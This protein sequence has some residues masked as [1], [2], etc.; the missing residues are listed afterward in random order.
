M[1]SRATLVIPYSPD[2]ERVAYRDYVTEVLIWASA[3]ELSVQL[4][5]RGPRMHAILRGSQ[6]ALQAFSDYFAVSEVLP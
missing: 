5:P 4:K 6:H 3:F 2:T 1:N